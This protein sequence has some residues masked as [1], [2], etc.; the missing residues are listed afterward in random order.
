MKDN[1]GLTLKFGRKGIG[2]ALLKHP[3]FQKLRESVVYLF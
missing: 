3:Y 2:S 1:F